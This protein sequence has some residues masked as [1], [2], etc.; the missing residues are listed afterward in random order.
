MSTMKDL[1]HTA[2]SNLLAIDEKYASPKC[3]AENC[4]QK[5]WAGECRRSLTDPE[6]FWEDYA[7]KFLWMK[8]WSKVLSWDGVHHQWFVGG[9]TNITLNA[10]DRHAN[11]ARRNASPTSGSAKMVR[12]A[13]SP[14]VSSTGWSAAL[15]TA[16]S[17]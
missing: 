6:Q 3:V 1:S 5:D 4:L 16:S 13:S 9:K 12:S 17:P 8:P 7:L 10:L 15:P 11:S 14:T 2:I